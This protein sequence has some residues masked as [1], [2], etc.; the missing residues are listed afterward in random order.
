MP[1][2]EASSFSE[3]VLMSIRAPAFLASAFASAF[4]ASALGVASAFFAGASVFFAS[5]AG[6]AFW[7]SAPPAN[8][9]PSAARAANVSRWIF[10]G[11]APLWG[12]WG[13]AAGR[14]QFTAWQKKAPPGRGF[15]FLRGAYA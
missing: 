11:T 6:S 14:R 8:A 3:A 12:L 1:F 10:M 5:L 9:R 4:L 15:C 7:A 13:N 2:S